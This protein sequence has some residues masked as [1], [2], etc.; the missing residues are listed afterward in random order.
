[1]GH[2]SPAETL[3]KDLLEIW[4]NR[5]YSEI[6]GVVSESFVMYDPVAPEDD[7]TGPK[8]EVHG[9]DGLEEFIREVVLGFPDFHVEILEMSANEDVAMYEG[10]ITLTHT[11]TYY[12]IPP[13]NQEATFRYMGIT[14]I[15]DGKVDEHRVYFDL[16]VVVE[17]L[18]LALPSIIFHLP[19]LVWAK[20]RE[21]T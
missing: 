8:W 16:Q 3:T 17:Q 2:T 12:W 11:G 9:P 21:I 15:E 5:L 10:I 18:G 19:R 20:L 13:T 1:M 4:N 7:V 6:P 14:R